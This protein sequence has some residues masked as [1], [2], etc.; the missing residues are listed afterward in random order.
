M[1]CAATIEASISVKMQQSP[2][3]FSAAAKLVRIAVGV[4]LVVL[5]ARAMTTSTSMT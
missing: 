1:M 2:L 4:V 5:V 3:G